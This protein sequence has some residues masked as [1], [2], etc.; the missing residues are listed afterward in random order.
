M[1]FLQFTCVMS[2]VTHSEP[3][4]PMVKDV[5]RN[6]KLK[7]RKDYRR[8]VSQLT[9][10]RCTQLETPTHEVKTAWLGLQGLTKGNIGKGTKQLKTHTIHI[11]TCGLPQALLCFFIRIYVTVVMMLSRTSNFILDLVSKKLYGLRLR[12]IVTIVSRSYVT[13]KIESE[14]LSFTYVFG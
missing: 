13:G 7:F 14:S 5:R 11:R 9:S 12:P 10:K 4:L 3:G 6:R 8:R 1:C 2:R